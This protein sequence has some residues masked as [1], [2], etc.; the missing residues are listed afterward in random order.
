MET[1]ATTVVRDDDGTFAVYDK[2]RA[3]QNVRDHL[4]THNLAD[5]HVPVIADVEDVEV[6][7]VE[8]RDE[9]VNPLG[10]NG[11]GEIGEVLHAPSLAAR[12]LLN[13]LTHLG[14]TTRLTRVLRPLV[15][16]VRCDG[17]FP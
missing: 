14:P 4:R 9:L 12:R 7:F 11:L 15:E 17:G 8:E 2:T 13:F 3:V 16:H 10:A 1:F 5:H 6:I